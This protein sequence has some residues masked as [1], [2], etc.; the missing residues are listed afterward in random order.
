MFVNAKNGLFENC[1]MSLDACK[2]GFLAGCRPIIVIAS[3]HIKNRF[4]GVMLAAVGV[5]LNDCI[6]HLAIAIVEV[7]DT[8]TWKWLLSTLKKD[9]EIQNTRPWTCMSDRQKVHN[10]NYDY[11]IL[12]PCV[13]SFGSV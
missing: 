5:D 7:E 12:F 10:Y 8:N 2:R 13:Y 9:L 1:Y 6:F 3:C 11:C 4:G